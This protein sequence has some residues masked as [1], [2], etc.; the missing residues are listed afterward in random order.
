[1]IGGKERGGCALSLGREHVEMRS[2]ALGG[3]AMRAEQS[4][5]PSD[6]SGAAES[7]VGVGERVAA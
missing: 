2:G 4:N 3:Q 6:G 1:M 7:C 5:L